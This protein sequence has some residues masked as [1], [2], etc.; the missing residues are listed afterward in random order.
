MTTTSKFGSKASIEKVINDEN[1]DNLISSIEK[2][3]NDLQ[4]FNNEDS[5][6]SKSENSTNKDSKKIKNDDEDTGNIH[7]I[8]GEEE[9]ERDEEE[10]EKKMLDELQKQQ[11]ITLDNN[12]FINAKVDCERRP[13]GFQSTKVLSHNTLKLDNDVVK[14]EEEVR[15]E[16]GDNSEYVLDPSEKFYIRKKMV[17][18]NLKKVEFKP[19]PTNFGK[20]G[21][22]KEIAKSKIDNYNESNTTEEDHESEM[23]KK[24]LQD[25]KNVKFSVKKI[26]FEYK[27]NDDEL[28]DFV[29]IRKKSSGKVQAKKIKKSSFSSEEENNEDKESEEGENDGLSEKERQKLKEIKEQRMKSQLAKEIETIEK[30]K[31]SH[32]LDKKLKEENVKKFGGGKTP[33]SSSSKSSSKGKKN[34]KNEK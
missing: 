27:E 19:A 31:F 23:K 29:P 26:V 1:E 32:G 8:E 24:L 10:E 18:D 11:H 5:I 20:Y 3:D 28:P 7:M 4:D 6:D 22:S 25:K 16:I 2:D 21:T 34:K 12:K 30:M 9:D 14:I 33:S 13:R 15:F 17:T